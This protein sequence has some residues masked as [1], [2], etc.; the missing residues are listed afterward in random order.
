MIGAYEGHYNSELHIQVS[1]SSA[2]QGRSGL[3]VPCRQPGYR[4]RTINGR[5]KGRRCD[6][7]L[8]E[9]T[10]RKWGTRFLGISL[11]FASRSVVLCK[12]QKMDHIMSVVVKTVN[13]IR[14]RG[15]N[16]HQFDTFLRD[17]DIQAG[18]PYHTEVRWLSRGAVLKRF[19]ELREE[20][21]QF[22]EKKGSPV[23][24]LKCPQWVQDLAFIVYI[25]QHLNYLNKMLQGRKKNVTQY[26]DSIRAFKL[27]LSLWE[28]RLSIG[29]T[30]HFP[31]LTAV[32]AT[33]R[34]ADMDQYKDKITGLLQEFVFSELVH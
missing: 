5:E 17:N 28:K 2:G 27:K 8:R 24:E 11:Y 6:K 26:H 9:S 33:G 12:T 21:G 22:M 1:R 25:T 10:D 32:R 7:I 18:L 29:D 20:I 30:A 34:N 3:V 19:F 4:W 14:A 13:F 23:K 31:C 15:L 16:H